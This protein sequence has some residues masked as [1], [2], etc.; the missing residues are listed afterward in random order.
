MSPHVADIY[1]VFEQ[2]WSEDMAGIFSADW[3]GSTAIIIVMEKYVR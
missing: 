1:D 3:Q 2:A